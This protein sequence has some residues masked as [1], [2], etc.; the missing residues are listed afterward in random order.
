MR[1][2]VTLILDSIEQSL[3]EAHTAL[4]KNSVDRAGELARG[5]VIE[6]EHLIDN[7]DLGNI[8]SQN[9]L[10]FRAVNLLAHAYNIL[11]SVALSRRDF[12]ETTH[13]ATLALELSERTHN[14]ERKAHLFVLLGNVN[15]Q[16]SEYNI[17]LEYLT[18]ARVL[19]EKLGR[20]DL[21]ATVLGRM[22]IAY[23]ELTDYSTALEHFQKALELHREHGNNDGIAANTINTAIVY[24]AFGDYPRALASFETA[25]SM[26]E[27]LDD[28]LA[29]AFTLSSI[30]GLYFR[31]EEFEKAMEL[32]QRALERQ[33]ELGAL[34]DATVSRGNLGHVY[35]SIG[36]YDKALE[37]LMRAL[38]ESI[39]I[40]AVYPQLHWLN[41]LGDLYSDMEFAGYSPEKAEEFFLKAVELSKE[42]GI[43]S[44]SSVA[45]QSLDALYRQTKN[46]EKAYEARNH[47]E[48]LKEQINIAGAQRQAAKQEQERK[49][50]E[51]EKQIST[52]RARSQEKES[53]LNNILPE[54]ITARLIKGESP[55]A[56]HFD[57]V[58]VLFMDIV[59]FT[60]LASRITAQQ[61]VHLLNAIFKAAD[62]VM[63]ECGLEKIKTIG[64]AYMAVAGAPTPC[65]DHAHRASHAAMKL[66]DVMKNLE[67]AIP[68][69]YGDR[70][71][72][73]S[74]PEIHVRIGL[75]C[76]SV[77]AGV[78]GENKFLYDLWGDAVNTASRMESHGEPGKI[79]VS[80][81]F[82]NSVGSEFTFIER[83]EMEI[84]GKGKMKTYFLEL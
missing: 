32:F 57:S 73:A 53:I 82:R 80:E 22:G 17:A 67:I 59:D 42:H 78:V 60:P 35:K 61:L 66:L 9:S 10:S 11:S 68:E 5:A 33:S 30:G 58:S 79:H 36:D 71:W 18:D 12:D 44:I 15:L 29:I 52:E 48:M 54:E 27:E 39:A 41:G 45:Y 63:R 83:G 72:R 25:L 51:R 16:K 38:D 31:T 77:A 24:Q 28:K 19:F 7:L 47:Y 50:A 13:F 34:R 62:G 6:I 70:S 4:D 81:D 37:Y 76:G 20:S 2:D 1:N 56:D 55:I 26:Y 69:E 8:Q 23:K 43:R 3:A 49:E 21:Q 64:D 65:E 84:K 14:L 40:H 46:W 74:I 75:H